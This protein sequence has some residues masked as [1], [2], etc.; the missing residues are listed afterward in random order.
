MFELKRSNSK[1]VFHI[2][3]N[4]DTPFETMVQLCQLSENLIGKT[5]NHS[6]HSKVKPPSSITGSQTK[7]GERP[8]SSIQMGTYDE[9]SEGV[10][11]KFLAFAEKRFEAIKMFQ[12]ATGISMLGCRDIVYGNYPCPILIKETAEFVMDELKKLNVYATLEDAHE[13]DDG[14]LTHRPE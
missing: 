11:I 8:V 14:V 9:P 12:G 5:Q 2:Q 4:D 10:R 3:L 7:L 1:G 6:A 13:D